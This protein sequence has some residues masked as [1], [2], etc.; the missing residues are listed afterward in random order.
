MKTIVIGDIHEG[1]KALKQL[2]ERANVS[3]EDKII[4]LGDL[5]DGWSESV[6]V[7]SFLIE[8]SKTHQCVFIK[9]NHDSWCLQWLVTKKT[10]LDWLK[11]GGRETFLGYSKVDEE[12]IKEHVTFFEN[13]KDYYLDNENRLFLHAGY[14]SLHGVEKET[15]KSNFYWDRTLWETALALDERIAVESPYFPKRLKKYKDIYIGHTPTKHYNETKP[16]QKANLWNLDT[17]A[18]YEGSLTAMDIETKEIWQ[19]DPVFELYSDEDGRN[20]S[21]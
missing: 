16:M 7:I 1:F 12:L 15:Y 11:Y 3:I 19:S 6:E 10:N 21:G 8:F 5:V 18:A 17:G 4:F 20:F 9:G 2:L 13:M 14:T